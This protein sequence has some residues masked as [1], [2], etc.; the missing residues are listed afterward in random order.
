MRSKGLIKSPVLWA[1]MLLGFGVSLTLAA[2]LDIRFDEAFT[3]NT[4]SRDV[5]YAFH[6]A[7]KFEQQ[8]PLYFVLLTVWRDIDSSIFFARLFSVLCLP[9]IIWVSAEVAKR[10]VKGV[11]PLVKAILLRNCNKSILTFVIVGQSQG[12]VGMKD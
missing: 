11:N 6:Q 5:V 8:A 12:R 9:F 2:L 1:L 10:Y 7:I 4:T 3:L